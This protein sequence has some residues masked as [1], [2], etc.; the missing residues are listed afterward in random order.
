MAGSN[1]G[2]R[3]E[4]EHTVAAL[5]HACKARVAAGSTLSDCLSI[6]HVF[7]REPTCHRVVSADFLIQCVFVHEPARHRVV[8]RISCR[9]LGVT[10]RQQTSEQY[11]T[12]FGPN[13]LT[14][15]HRSNSVQL[16]RVQTLV[17]GTR[18]RLALA[19]R[20]VHHSQI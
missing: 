4:R 14:C 18:C 12:D 11:R 13:G 7:D 15:R 10:D 19:Y 3:M 17:I 1:L 20:T 2:R 9:K 16:E 6:Q 8:W 5:D